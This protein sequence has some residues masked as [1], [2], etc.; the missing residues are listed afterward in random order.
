[1]RAAALA[2]LLA[3]PAAARPPR[4]RCDPRVDLLGIV[5]LLAGLRVQSSR[6]LFDIRER[7]AKHASHPVVARYIR[8]VSRGGGRGDE[9][10]ALILTAV[11]R[12]PELRWTRG[13]K[14]LSPEFIEAAGGMREVEAFLG[15]LRDFAAKTGAPDFPGRDA[16][17]RDA[18]ERARSE[19]ARRDP[20]R[21]LEDYLGRPL[22]VRLELALSP[23]YVPTRWAAYL[24]PYPRAGVK[25]P[26]E[27]F[28]VVT[29]EPSAPDGERPGWRLRDPFRGG[30][31]NEA[32]YVA[33][34]PGW[35][36]HRAAFD[37]RAGLL[38]TMPGCAPSWHGCALRIAVAA[39]AR[40]AAR[41]GEESPA[42]RDIEAAIQR[43][44]WALKSDYE[45]GKAAKRYRS[46]DDFWPR[47]AEALGP[48]DP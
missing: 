31:M 25:G 2:V 30:V 42:P 22:D 26:F 32:V 5:Q 10:Y 44:E 4:P 8:T 48:K 34:E 27:A 43:V 18:A 3:L 46:I 45:P 39:I 41:G 6:V 12:P 47:I 11:S 15:E 21:E 24:H 13:A 38:K 35:D 37:A 16:L 28:V 29:P 14:S 40:R 9:P 1:M 23:V 33:A 17:C 36:K 7:Y 20:V 19:L